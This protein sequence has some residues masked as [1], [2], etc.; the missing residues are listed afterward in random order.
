M[1]NEVVVLIAEDDDG[2]AQLIKRNLQ[3]SGIKN[4][5]QRFCDG[6]EILDFLL[7]KQDMQKLPRESYVLLLDIRM[8]GID[9]IEVLRT[10]KSNPATKR[11][12]IIMLTTTDDPQEIKRCHDLG[13]NTYITK[14]IKYENFITAI[15]QLGLFLLIIEVP[16]IDILPVSSA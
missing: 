15:R 14:P 13:C 3:R 16:N 1:T 2:H 10:L 4:K 12:P 6:K 11:L 7:N 8:P 9:G 5:I